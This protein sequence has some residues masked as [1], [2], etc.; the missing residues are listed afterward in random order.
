MIASSGGVE[1]D[2]VIVCVNCRQQVQH[3]LHV[4]CCECPAVMCVDCFSYGCEAGRHLRGHNYEIRDPLG[5]RTFESKGSWGAAEERKLLS[6]AYRFKLGNWSEV[7]RMMETNRPINQVQEYYDRFFIRGPI[8]QFAL[9]LLSWKENK[10]RMIADNSFDY[11]CEVDRVNYMLMAMDALRESKEKLDPKDEDLLNKVDAILRNYIVDMQSCE[12]QLCGDRCGISEVHDLALS[13]DSC[14]PSDAEMCKNKVTEDQYSTGLEPENDSD[15]DNSNTVQPSSAR[16][17]RCSL[18]KSTLQKSGKPSRYRRLQADSS[19]S[20]E[21]YVDGETWETDRV[22]VENTQES[23]HGLE[24]EETT[25]DY[26]VSDSE[27][28]KPEFTRRNNLTG[29]V[30]RRRRARRVNSFLIQLSEL[31][32]AEKIFELRA[33]KPE[34]ALY[35]NEYSVVPKVRQSDMDMLA[36]NAARSDFEWE[37]YNDAEHLISRMMIQES[38]DRVED[39]ENDIKFARI[40]KRV[41][42]FSRYFPDFFFFLSGNRSRYNRILKIRKT[43]RRAIIEHDKISEFFRF[44]MNMTMEK[45]KA[46]QIFYQ[47]PPLE[48]FMARAQQCLT[49]RESEDLRGNVERADRLME[50]ISKLQELQRSGVSSLKE[51]ASDGKLTSVGTNAS[52]AT[53]TS[54]VFQ[55]FTNKLINEKIR[56]RRILLHNQIGVSKLLFIC[57]SGHIKLEIEVITSR[58]RQISPFHN[59]LTILLVKLEENVT[60][61]ISICS[62]VY[63]KINSP[64]LINVPDTS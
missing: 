12:T 49:R 5:G 51:L 61:N 45:R 40:E 41:Y 58:W 17:I 47:R 16:K 21:D 33:S 55:K 8:G 29:T 31:C 48:K 19:S 3:Q 36:Y 30:R 20:D 34:L 6:A 56:E 35:C 39:F 26:T 13:D 60:I 4:K 23:M 42:E 25:D 22:S 7:T 53:T 24:R 52:G 62:N 37:W 44:M 59:H 57:S 1:S 46:S 32:P 2:E 9:K 15:E 18:R 64:N 11:E 14:D 63:K 27:E 54:E 28:P 38:S 43:Y 50:R 10:K